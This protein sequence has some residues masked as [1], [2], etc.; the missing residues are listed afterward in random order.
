MP[1]ERILEWNLPVTA[2]DEYL[3]RVVVGPI[4]KGT[5]ER[6]KAV[7]GSRLGGKETNP[8]HYKECRTFVEKTRFEFV[9]ANFPF[10]RLSID[11]VPTQHSADAATLE[12]EVP[13]GD[14]CIEAVLGYPRLTL[15]GFVFS[16]CALLLFFLFLARLRGSQ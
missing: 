11:G 3:P 12:V 2:G 10:W 1:P 4:T 16:A 6:W 9:L 5:S 15:A 7:A 13:A 14:H 8:T